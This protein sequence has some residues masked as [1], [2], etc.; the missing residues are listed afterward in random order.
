[1]LCLFKFE[2]DPPTHPSKWGPHQHVMPMAP[3]THLWGSDWYGFSNPEPFSHFDARATEERQRWFPIDE[4]GH[5]CSD[6]VHLG[7]C[8]AVKLR[9]LW[10]SS[11]VVGA[12]FPQI[13]FWW[14]VE[15]PATIHFFCL[16]RRSSSI[17][18]LNISAPRSCKDGVALLMFPKVRINS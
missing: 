11:V 14:R 3:A 12:G 17:F 18:I 5:R 4:S 15:T 16:A 2:E 1:M 10:K 6:L 8:G 7:T 13:A 9:N